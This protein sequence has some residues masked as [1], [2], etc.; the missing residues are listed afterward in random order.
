MT[1]NQ[2]G[3]DASDELECSAATSGD[4]QQ[5][6]WKDFQTAPNAVR[7][8]SPSHHPKSPKWVGHDTH[9]RLERAAWQYSMDAT[10]GLSD[11]QNRSADRAPGFSSPPPPVYSTTAVVTNR[12][13]AKVFA[14]YVKQAGPWVCRESRAE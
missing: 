5:P 9:A 13:D 7:Y 4:F 11:G 2:I 14:F 10:S 3:H 6:N 8:G 12:L 1:Y